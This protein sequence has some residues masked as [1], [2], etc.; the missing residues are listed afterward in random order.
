MFTP[1]AASR[2]SAQRR[3]GWR[4]FFVGLLGLRVLCCGPSPLF[5]IFTITGFFHA[6]VLRPL[7]LAI[8]RRRPRRRS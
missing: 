6:S 8:A 3:S 1:G 2:G 7:P 5:F 4:I